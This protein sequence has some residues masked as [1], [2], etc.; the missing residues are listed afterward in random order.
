M[1][2]L[3]DVRF[4]VVCVRAYERADPGDMAFYKCL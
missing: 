3:Y 4:I 2:L 1:K